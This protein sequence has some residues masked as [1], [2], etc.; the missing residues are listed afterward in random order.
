M[1]ASVY[2]RKKPRRQNNKSLPYELVRIFRDKLQITSEWQLPLGVDRSYIEAL[3]HA[4]VP[5]AGDLLE[6][7]DDNNGEI[8]F[9]IEY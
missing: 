4:D 6:M 8:E 9:K 1:S 5:G 2:V 7:W 3:W